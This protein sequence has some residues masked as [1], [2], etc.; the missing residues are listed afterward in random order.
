D[1]LPSVWLWVYICF[2]QFLDEASLTTIRCEDNCKILPFGKL[3]M[4]KNYEQLYFSVKG[5]EACKILCMVDMVSRQC[6]QYSSED[7]SQEG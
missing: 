3:T 7:L 4:S 5:K 1:S 2:H 6:Q